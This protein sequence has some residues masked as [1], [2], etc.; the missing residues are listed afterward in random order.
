MLGTWYSITTQIHGVVNNITF[1]VLSLHSW[2]IVIPWESHLEFKPERAFKSRGMALQHNLATQFGLIIP[3]HF[4]SYGLSIVKIYGNICCVITGHR[5]VFPLTCTAVAASTCTPE[6]FNRRRTRP[7]CP[8]WAARWSGVKP[9]C[10]CKIVWNNSY[11]RTGKQT[12]NHI[13]RLH[14]K[15]WPLLMT[16]DQKKICQH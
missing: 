13:H 8:D 6:E 7:S 9:C 12:D 11:C 1:K 2:W 10:N 3:L 5:T 4:A 15:V 16:W 14:A